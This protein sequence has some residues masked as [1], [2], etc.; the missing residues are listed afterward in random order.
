MSWGAVT[1]RCSA[2]LRRGGND[3]LLTLERRA[4]ALALVTSHRPSQISVPVLPVKVTQEK[5]R[6][7]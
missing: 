6:D 7:F 2:V 5:A 4:E 1:D 3:P